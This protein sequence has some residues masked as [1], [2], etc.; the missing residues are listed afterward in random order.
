MIFIDCPWFDDKF[1]TI[2]VADQSYDSKGWRPLVLVIWHMGV[3]FHIVLIFYM[4][5]WLL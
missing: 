2:Y 5:V 4:F 3:H 1:D